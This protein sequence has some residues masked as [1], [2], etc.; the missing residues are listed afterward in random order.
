M[1][2]GDCFFAWWDDL[3]QRHQWFLIVHLSIPQKQ[4]GSREKARHG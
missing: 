4:S 3:G 1:I 2:Y